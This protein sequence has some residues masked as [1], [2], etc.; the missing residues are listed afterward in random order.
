MGRDGDGEGRKEGERSLEPLG[1]GR[2][3]DGESGGRSRGKTLAA[4]TPPPPHT[5][6][7]GLLGNDGDGKKKESRTQGENRWRQRKM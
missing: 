5:H 4:N 7:R 2:K 6:T 1:P 3:C